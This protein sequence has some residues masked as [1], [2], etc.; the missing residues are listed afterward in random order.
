MLGTALVAALT[1]SGVMAEEMV[2]GAVGRRVE[3]AERVD[4][5]AMLKPRCQ[6]SESCLACECKYQRLL[7]ELRE[8]D[9]HKGTRQRAD[10]RERERERERDREG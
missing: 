6:P 9:V 5:A 4:T 2:T 1:A 10:K 3:S 7:H 8:R